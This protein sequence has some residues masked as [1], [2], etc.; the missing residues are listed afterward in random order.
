MLRSFKVVLW[1][2]LAVTTPFSLALAQNKANPKASLDERNVLL[3]KEAVAQRHFS[4]TMRGIRA[5]HEGKYD[6]S[7]A[8]FKEIIE[9]EPEHPLGYFL[10]CVAIERKMYDYK[11]FSL[12]ETFL[13]NIKKAVETSNKLLAKDSN[14][15]W[16]N[17]YVGLSRGTRALYAHDFGNFFGSFFDGLMAARYMGK[18]LKMDPSL[19]DAGYGVNL[20]KYWSNYYLR[21]VGS[22]AKRGEAIEDLKVL[23]KKGVYTKL[24][25]QSSLVEILFTEKRYDEGQA[26]IRDI[27]KSFS[28]N[29]HLR[30]YQAKGYVR[31]GELK[32]ARE[33]YLWLQD[34]FLKR[35]SQESLA[36]VH[37]RA[38]LAN[39]SF[40]LGRKDEGKQFA[41]SA[42]KDLNA[43]AKE[44]GLPEGEE[45]RFVSDLRKT[46]QKAQ[47]SSK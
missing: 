22:E 8:L 7:F 43:R 12:E 10:Y 20:W 28:D 41:E 1:L 4:K 33:A 45:K 42:L 5:M 37:I 18:A 26:Y 40:L 6:E 29:L 11:D 30:W 2:F 24:G 14:D 9:A 32:E 47:K 21:V 13:E 46:L 39:I 44:R 25:A 15:A 23:A 35:Y 19:I 36:L 16:S 3:V 38:E 17:F 27:L 31:S 34:Y